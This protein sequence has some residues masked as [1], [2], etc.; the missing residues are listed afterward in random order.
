MYCININR[1][2]VRHRQVPLD[3]W[4]SHD[5][6]NK[7]SDEREL[8]EILKE[9]RSFV[10]EYNDLSDKGELEA[11]WTRK[12]EKTVLAVLLV[13]LECQ[14][15]DD[16][17]LSKIKTFSITD[18]NGKD[19]IFA[20]FRG[21]NSEISLPC[22]STCAERAAITTAHTQIMNVKRS[23]FRMIAVMDPLNEML[24]LQPCGVCHEW[25]LKFQ[26][27]SPKFKII[28][29]PIANDFNTITE[30]FPAQYQLKEAPI[31]D[32]DDVD[33]DG[34][35]DHDGDGDGDGDGEIDTDGRGDGENTEETDVNRIE[36]RADS[37]DTDSGKSIMKMKRKQTKKKKGKSDGRAQH[38]IS[39]EMWS[40]EICERPNIGL[41]KRCMNCGWSSNVKHRAILYRNIVAATKIFDIIGELN[42]TKENGEFKY[43]DIQ[44]KLIQCGNDETFDA[45]AAISF[46]NSGLM[47]WLL[48][49]KVLARKKSKRYE[50][51]PEFGQFNQFTTIA[52]ENLDQGNV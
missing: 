19:R 47:P 27:E 28:S 12:S 1:Q 16:L 37:G 14:G 36:T 34:D 15:N 30:R 3:K 43:K 11:F 26:E 24:D 49:K 45:D 21:R 22:G 38:K 44:E 31:H 32:T 13:E 9:M 10:Q 39:N 52:V 29:Y 20:L 2:F 51:G 46:L 33:Q 42:S 17:D 23:Q 6:S 50:I 4:S 25:I 5:M 7:N 40:C 48:E 35:G 41:A 18:R 8:Y